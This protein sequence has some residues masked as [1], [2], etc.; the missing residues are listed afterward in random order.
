MDRGKHKALFNND[1]SSSQCTGFNFQG[2]ARNEEVCNFKENPSEASSESFATSHPRPKVGTCT[3]LLSFMV[4]A[5]EFFAKDQEA[6]C[7]QGSIKA[8]YDTMTALSETDF[9]DD[10]KSIKIPLLVMHGLDDQIVPFPFAGQL[11]HQLVKGSQLKTYPG[12]PHGM[13][14]THA[15]VINADLLTF[16]QG[17]LAPP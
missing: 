11:S 8:H 4:L 3:L 10:L 13:C 6:A 1:V 7:Q 17:T 15:D 16:I 2:P 5:R 9:T 14:T 12:F